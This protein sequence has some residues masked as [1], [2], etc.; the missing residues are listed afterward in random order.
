MTKS[1]IPI[2]EMLKSTKKFATVSLTLAKTNRASKHNI[3]PENRLLD[4][5]K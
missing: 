5:I 4:L 2:V 1:M 3:N